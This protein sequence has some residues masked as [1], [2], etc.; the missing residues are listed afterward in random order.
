MKSFTRILHIDCLGSTPSVKGQMSLAFAEKDVWL[1][2][3]LQ[4]KC[5]LFII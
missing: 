4:A 2:V 5:I 1:F 3:F